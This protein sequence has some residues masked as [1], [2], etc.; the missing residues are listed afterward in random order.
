[1][2]KILFLIVYTAYVFYPINLWVGITLTLT[3]NSWRPSDVCVSKLT[4]IG[5]DNGLSPGRR[6]AILW[7]NYGILIIRTLETNFSEIV[8]KIHTFSFKKMH[9][10]MS[11][12]KWRLFGFGLNVLTHGDGVAHAC[13][14]KLGHH[15][16]RKWL[17]VFS[18]QSRFLDQRLIIINHGEFR[19]NL[20]LN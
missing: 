1:M 5:S 15:W 19:G 7:T 8:S 18:A 11:S 4:I 17:V 6:Q 12:A 2:L 20:I 13:V 10:K 9:L 16:F 14:S 3:L